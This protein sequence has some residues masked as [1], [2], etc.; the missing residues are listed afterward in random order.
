MKYKT[1]FTS[2]LLATT[3]SLIACGSDSDQGSSSQPDTGAPPHPSTPSSPVTPGTPVTDE[4]K[5]EAKVVADFFLNMITAESLGRGLIDRVGYFQDEVFEDDSNCSSAVSEQ[6]QTS[7]STYTVNKACF[8]AYDIAETF[9]VLSGSFTDSGDFDSTIGGSSTLNN[10][11]LKIG[12]RTF[13]LNGTIQYANITGGEKQTSNDLVISL[14]TGEK[15]K[16]KDLEFLRLDRQSNSKAQSSIK[17]QMIT[18]GF[19]QVYDVKFENVSPWQSTINDDDIFADPTAGKLSVEYTHDPSRYL[20]LE[21]MA[22][23]TQ[24][25]YFAKAG[26]YII[27]DHTLLKWSDVIVSPDKYTLEP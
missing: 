18:E 23:G 12:E 25:S 2:T 14:E 10:I 7:S 26:D 8:V 11:K 6:K 21:A 1:L 4:E 27:S 20:T 19:D 22:N 13:I 5:Q 16:F 17:G 3:L 9:S 15:F 24:A